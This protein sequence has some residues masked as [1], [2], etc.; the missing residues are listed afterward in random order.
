[1]KRRLI[2]LLFYS[3]SVHVVYHHSDFCRWKVRCLHPLIRSICTGCDGLCET[4]LSVLI[5]RSHRS[6]SWL[7][8]M[9]RERRNFNQLQSACWKTITFIRSL[10]L[11]KGQV[12]L[13][14][15]DEERVNVFAGRSVALIKFRIYSDPFQKRQDL[16]WMI[17]SGSIQIS[18]VTMS[19]CYYRWLII[20]RKGR[21]S[22]DPKFSSSCSPNRPAS[23]WQDPTQSWI[24]PFERIE[25]FLNSYSLNFRSCSRSWIIQANC[26]CTTCEFFVSIEYVSTSWIVLIASR[27]FK[28]YQARSTVTRKN[29]YYGQLFQNIV[30]CH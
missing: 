4:S 23:N 12:F 17:N 26:D 19:H 29:V 30:W 28:I 6:A 2:L 15:V 21:L 11:G 1:M 7:I 18:F 27:C 8:A 22:A 20:L 3:I 13:E 25:N 14:G 24:S 16:A 9:T 5:I 10:D